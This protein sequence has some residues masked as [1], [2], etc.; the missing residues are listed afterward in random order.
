MHLRTLTITIVCLV[1]G[2]TIIHNLWFDEGK[3]IVGNVASEQVA[4]SIEIPFEDKTIAS[5]HIL[6]FQV[7]LHQI[8]TSRLRRDIIV[9]S[10]LKDPEG[11]K[12]EL[13]SETA[14][15]E[16]QASFALSYVLPTLK[17]PEYTLVVEAR[18]LREDT[19]LGRASYALIHEEEVYFTPEYQNNVYLI[20]IFLVIG[21]VIGAVLIMFIYFIIFKK[22][23]NRFNNPPPYKEK[24]GTKRGK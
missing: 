16:T 22:A 6:R 5:G 4:L 24:R 23:S 19:L 12:F 1:L 3:T 20:S 17:S 18:S 2:G 15:L 10:F 13:G 9:S 8:G 11:K 7:Y 21:M 14:A